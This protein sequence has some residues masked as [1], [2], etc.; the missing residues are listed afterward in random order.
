MDCCPG[1]AR[2]RRRVLRR[3]LACAFVVA[4]ASA[5]PPPA[6]GGAGPCEGY[7]YQ[8]SLSFSAADPWALTAPADSGS[9][10]VYLWY[11]CNFEGGMSAAEFAV[12]TGGSLSVVD[13]TPMNGFLSYGTPSQLLLA[14]PG[15]PWSPLV[16]GAFTMHSAT[17]AGGF[18]CFA[19]S[20]PD[21]LNVTEDC[22]NPVPG[23][24]P[25]GY[26]GIS[27]DGSSPCSSAPMPVEPTSWGSTKALYR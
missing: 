23:Q 26:R 20:S 10:T 7:H 15:C 24:Y 12:R 4:A 11:A 2:R 1:K 17:Q 5:L 9:V 13:F 21:D 19:P 22:S 16:A 25:N 14:R 8:W 3:R 6:A 27:T 18:A